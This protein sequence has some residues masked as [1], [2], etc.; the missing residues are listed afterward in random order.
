[1]KTQTKTI[2]RL[3]RNISETKQSEISVIFPL[4]YITSKDF[5][6]AITKIVTVFIDYER[7]I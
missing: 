6:P 4:L 1:M 3:Y 5:L 2:I 7:T